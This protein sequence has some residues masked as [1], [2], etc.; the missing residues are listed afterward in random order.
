MK[1]SIWIKDKLLSLIKEMD[2]YH[3][4]FTRN[5]EKD[6]SRVKK[7]SFGEIIR[8]II[9][10][11]GK[12]LKDE[13]LEHFNF[14]NET[15]T[16]SSFNQRRA[17]ILPDAFEFLFH[18]F[19]QYVSKEHLF[20]GYRLLAC[21]G[22][23][24]TTAPNPQ[25]EA[26]YIQCTPDSKGYNQLPMWMLLFTRFAMQMKT[27]I[28]VTWLTDTEAFIKRFSSQIEDMKAITL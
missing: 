6:F 18:E 9:S 25:D 12:S 21:D 11:E 16:N 15:P 24:L 8:F 22:S 5:A 13:L 17:Q 14:S 26:A 7:W 27:K 2:H 28:C 4:L 23:V 10:M 20:R 19:S 1:Y 3:W